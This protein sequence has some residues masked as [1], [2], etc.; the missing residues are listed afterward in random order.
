MVKTEW[1]KSYTASELPDKFDRVM[2]SWDTANKPTEL[3]DYSVCTT[4]G[5]KEKRIYLLN[6]FRKRL[7]YPNLKRAVQEQF[8]LY[9]PSIVLIEDK[10]SGTQL[11]QEMREAGVHA[12]MAYKSKF[13]KIMRLDA[14]TGVIENGLVYLPTE[15]HW[16]AEYLHELSTFPKS[17]YDDQV[18]STS[19][20]LE[21][22]KQRVPGWGLLQYYADLVEEL[23]AGS[24]SR[25][26]TLKVP[27]GISHVGTITGRQVMVRP[28]GTI[29]VSEEEAVSLR[30]HGFHDVEAGLP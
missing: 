28:D 21:W 5:L 16:G 2:Q 14:Q 7:D 23:Q 29:E 17:K 30:G 15:A 24:S 6:V 1:F 13:E 27:T 22:L 20:A 12:V 8:N 26:I 18:D 19:Q 9:D 10:A 11:I 4:W 25:M 3:N